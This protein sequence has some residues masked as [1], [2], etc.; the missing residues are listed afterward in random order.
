[1]RGR[2]GQ[3][4]SNSMMGPE[5]VTPLPNLA[6]LTGLKTLNSCVPAGLASEPFGTS[7]LLTSR[8]NQYNRRQVP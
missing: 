1:M 7:Q 4:D 8:S 5:V 6:M 2:P 3:E